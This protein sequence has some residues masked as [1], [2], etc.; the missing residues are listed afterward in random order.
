MVHIQDIRYALRLLARSPGFTLLTVL[1][2][3]GGLG[4]STFTFSF[5][6]TAMIRPLPLSEGDRI[7]RLS[8]RED[9]NYRPVDAAD[10]AALRAS[11]RTVRDL[12]LI[13][14]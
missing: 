9:G 10:V 7:V 3:A 12:S 14:I 1:V 13:H 8:R 5:L 2:L 6:H 11:L 4:L